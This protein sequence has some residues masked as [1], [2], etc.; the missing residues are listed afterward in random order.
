MAVPGCIQQLCCP[1]R[2]QPNA[3]PGCKGD[4]GAVWAYSWGWGGWLVCHRTPLQ[5]LEWVPTA[6]KQRGEA[7]DSPALPRGLGTPACRE[8]AT[9]SG[10]DAFS[11]CPSPQSRDPLQ[12]QGPQAGRLAQLGAV[13]KGHPVRGSSAGSA[14]PPQLA[15]P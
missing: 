3:S 13:A 15:G 14:G 5:P 11:S 4:A 10:L 1:R 6:P 8:P 2:R 12:P 7:G 9:S